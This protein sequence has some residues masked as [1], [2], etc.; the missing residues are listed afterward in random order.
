MSAFLIGVALAAQVPAS[1]GPHPPAGNSGVY[2]QWKLG[3]INGYKEEKLAANRWRIDAQ[4]G[5][6]A[7]QDLALL[8]ALYRAAIVTKAAGRS[9]FFT[10]KMEIDNQLGGLVQGQNVYSTIVLHDEATPPPPYEA[11]PKWASNCRDNSADEVIAAIGPA[12][13]QDERAREAE[14]A[15]TRARYY[16]A[17]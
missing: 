2:Q 17:P 13:A 9:R 12:L 3:R 5:S 4:S 6:N 8:S 10:V 14:V 16:A 7:I 1:I 11:K 15:S